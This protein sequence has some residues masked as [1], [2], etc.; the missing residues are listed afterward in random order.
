MGAKI[1]I[2]SAT[3]MNKGLE[4]IEARWMF[5]IE[6]SRIDVLVHPQSIIHSMVVFKDGSTKAQLGVPDM[7]VPIQYALSYPGRWEAAHPRVDWKTLSKLD[8]EP[9]DLR[10]FPCLQLAYNAL[11][12]G[13]DLPA[14]L[15]AAN[16]AAVALF[17]QDRI[18]FID[19]PDIVAG[20]MA[21][22]S[23]GSNPSLEDLI[24]LH[25]EV[26]IHV[27]ELYRARAN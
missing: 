8:F 22:F 4:L 6:S 23:R 11:E 24:A 20:A 15:N 19:I 5:D 18:Q 3:L 26:K 7:R 17:L 13:G 27:Q 9:P 16:E 25:T 2:D 1:T 10:K 21:R 14:I 12:K